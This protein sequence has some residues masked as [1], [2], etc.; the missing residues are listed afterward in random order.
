M[1]Q[2]TKVNRRTE[3]VRRQQKQTNLA[4]SHARKVRLMAVLACT[5][6][7]RT[8]ASRV[9][10]TTTAKQC[11]GTDLA[12]R[13]HDGKRGKSMAGRGKVTPHARNWCWRANM[14][15]QPVWSV[16]EWIWVQLAKE[17]EN[18]CLY[19]VLEMTQLR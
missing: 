16:G 2:E 14:P 6:L 10:T 8:A 1:V 7:P 3:G 12:M 18:I 5:R 13:E 4:A 15:R 19:A 9:R 11:P 17:E